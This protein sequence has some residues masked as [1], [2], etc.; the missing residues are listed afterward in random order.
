M[1]PYNGDKAVY[2][3]KLFHFCLGQQEAMS[4]GQCEHS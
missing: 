2:G 3:P 4:G 1:S